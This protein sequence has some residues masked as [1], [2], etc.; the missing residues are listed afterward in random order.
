MKKTLLTFIAG[1][2]L[3]ISCTAPVAE[4]HYYN[5]AKP[6]DINTFFTSQEGLLISGHRG[7]NLEGYPENCVETFDKILE[8]IPTVYEIDPRMTKDR[9]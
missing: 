6:E 2:A 3:A 8:S 7:G 1:A 4:H 5:C 9:A